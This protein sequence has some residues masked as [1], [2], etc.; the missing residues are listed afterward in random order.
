MNEQQL[1]ESEYF[2]EPEQITIAEILEAPCIFCGYKGSGY[3]QKYSHKRGCV[4][5]FNGGLTERVSS[6]V[7]AAKEGRIRIVGNVHDVNEYY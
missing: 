5:Y 6:F 3:Y 2:K 1:I 4:W 7:K